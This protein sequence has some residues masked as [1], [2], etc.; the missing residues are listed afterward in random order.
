MLR[1]RV[2]DQISR[3][4]LSEVRSLARALAKE[5][6]LYCPYGLKKFEAE[7]ES[8]T[9]IQFRSEPKVLEMVK[10]LKELIPLVSQWYFPDHIIMA[11]AGL[12]RTTVAI[13][14]LLQDTYG[15]FEADYQRKNTEKMIRLVLS[16]SGLVNNPMPYRKL[17]GEKSSQRTWMLVK[18]VKAVDSDLFLEFNTRMKD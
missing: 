15:K 3:A 18:G 17:S 11:A 14:Y 12:P 7:F 5:V 9:E 2:Y 8:S 16:I 1:S 13:S 4:S 6:E 10:D